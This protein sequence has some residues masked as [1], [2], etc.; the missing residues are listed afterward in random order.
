MQP[1]DSRLIRQVPAVRRPLVLLGVLGVVGGVLAVAQAFAVAQL[2]VAVVRSED[3]GTPCAWVAGVLAARGIITGT[4]ELAAGWTGSRVAGVVRRHRLDRWLSSTVEHRPAPA[5]MVALSTDGAASIEPYVARY[6]PTLVTASVV[7]AL[8]VVALLVTDVWSALIV[9]LTLPLLP[10]F[11]ALIG[12]HTERATA[13]RWSELVSLGGHFLDV[14]RGLPTLVGYQR[15]TVQASTVRQ[16]SDRH[17]RATVRTLRT[18]FL[19]SAALEL[20]ATISVAMVAVGVGLRLAGGHLGLATALTAILL[21]PE[22]YWPIRRVG[23]EFHAAADGARA[24][25]DLLDDRVVMTRPGGHEMPT[26]SSRSIGQPDAV[27]RAHQL[28][29]RYPGAETDVVRRLDLTLSRGLTAVTGPSGCGK[30]TLLELL[31][32]LR[33]PTD[34][35]IAAP[36]AHLVTQRPFIAPATL[37]TNLALSAGPQVARPLHERLA[38][39]PASTVLGDD[40][41]GLSAGQRALLAIERARR[42]DATMLLLD[43]PTAHLDAEAAADVRELLTDLAR[44]RIVIVV[45]HDPELAAAADHQVALA[46][47]GGRREEAC[48]PPHQSSRRA[49]SPPQ[50]HRDQPD[51]RSTTV[52]RTPRRSS[53]TL[54]AGLVG[55]LAASSGVALTATSGW[56]VVRASERPV[57]LTLLT[58]IV[59][60]RAFGIGRPVLRYAE[61]VLSHDVALAELTERRVDAYRRLI[62]LTPA[63][64]GRRRR[65]DL[66]TGFVRDLDD[67]VDATV[68]VHIPLI[69]TVMA[70]VV[71]IGVTLAIVPASALVV[72]GLVAAVAVIAVID[73]LCERRTQATSLQARSD[74]ARA[75]HLAS[76]NALELQ[77]IS[78]SDYAITQLDEAQVRAE[79]GALRQAGGRAI[80]QAGTSVLVGLS[81]ITMAAVVATADITAPAAA[82]LLLVP[83]AL[84]EVLSGLPDAMGALARSR[85]AE[86]RVRALLSQEPAVAEPL[87]SVTGMHHP[88]TGVPRLRLTDVSATWDGRQAALP[89]TTLTIEPG[90]H[91]AV[92]GPNGSGKSTLLAVLARHLDP[93]SGRYALDDRDVRTRPLDD[94]R[95]RIAFVE[96]EPHVFA[97]TVRANLLLAR[98]GADD[99][100]VTHA[101]VDAG[102]GRWLAGLPEGLGTTLGSAGRGVSGGERARLG[103]ARA[104]LS[105]RPVVLLDEPVAHLDHPTA[106]AVLEDLHVATAS[107]TVVLVTH[108]QMAEDRCDTVL[109]WGA[110]HQVPARSMP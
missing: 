90:E 39:V 40:G 85:A 33:E 84:G 57:V 99:R 67:I 82:L 79:S 53:R 105:E 87:T 89:A 62:P 83:L 81:T 110:S 15:A 47:T 38:D 70:S 108:Q 7:P 72:V 77:A 30:T 74:V 22:A 6:L 34:G 11:A 16:I 31:A 26:R 29:Y 8:A 50:P 41:F 9:I 95:R 97:G 68:R 48:A 17:R 10:V 71:A 52:D 43:E 25:D 49:D 73:W 56:L 46:E 109:R 28:T 65:S 91:L 1:F 35:R 104:L 100:A 60:V 107:R 102:L 23:Q 61:R 75:A 98:P 24:L 93:V 19:S 101:L 92:T 21:A 63:R 18:A 96:D 13:G 20:L 4:A 14:V 54:V 58:A 64:L 45:T 36:R 103:I 80:G 12:K 2:V 66:L 51:N 42:S 94:V 55:G 86:R 27:A 44:D 78:A 88:A 5:E 76:S 32:G 106:A 3:L 59:A 37:D 69:A